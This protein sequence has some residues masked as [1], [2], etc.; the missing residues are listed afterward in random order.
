MRHIAVQGGDLCID[1]TLRFTL[2][3]EL[4]K[5]QNQHGPYAYCSLDKGAAMTGGGGY[6]N[7]LC[8]HKAPVCLET[9]IQQ[10]L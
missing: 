4:N 2:G 8:G 10:R 5:V 6:E 1:F 7:I 3:T 9:Q